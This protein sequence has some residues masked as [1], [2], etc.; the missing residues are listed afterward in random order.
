MHSNGVANTAVLVGHG[1]I[2]PVDTDS[3]FFIVTMYGLLTRYGSGT[4]LLTRHSQVKAT[5]AKSAQTRV[6]CLPKLPGVHIL[7]QSKLDGQRHKVHCADG[8]VR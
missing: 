6:V 2:H 4:V 1:R 3:I 7:A 5:A 8:R